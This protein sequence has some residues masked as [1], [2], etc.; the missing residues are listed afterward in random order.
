MWKNKDPDAYDWS[1][2]FKHVVHTLEGQND[3][4]TVN[5]RV[6]MLRSKIKDVLFCDVEDPNLLPEW[7]GGKFDIITSNACIEQ[8]C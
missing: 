7:T 4:N 2:Y 3:P 6:E 1:S 5:Q 8:I